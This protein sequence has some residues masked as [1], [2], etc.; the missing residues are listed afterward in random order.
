MMKGIEVNDPVALFIEG[1]KQVRRGII[2]REH[3]G[4]EERAV[5]YLIIAVTQGDDFSIESLKLAHKGGFVERN[6]LLLADALRAHQAAVDETKSTER[7]ANMN[8]ICEERI[9]CN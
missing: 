3:H 1:T 5:K 2:L 6:V 8:K 9:V 4:N 7:E